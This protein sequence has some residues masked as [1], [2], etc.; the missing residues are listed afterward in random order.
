MKTA[1]P[2]AELY[3]TWETDDLRNGCTEL[4]LRLES[5]KREGMEVASF[6]VNR[7]EAMKNELAQR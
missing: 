7:L 4:R 3:K 1:K 5:Y 6:W 2:L